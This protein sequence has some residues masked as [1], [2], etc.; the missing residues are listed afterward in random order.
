MKTKT[1][2]ATVKLDVR[3]QA[4]RQVVFDL[5]E[6]Q[7]LPPIEAVIDSMIYREG[8]D[9]FNRRASASSTLNS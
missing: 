6:K 3:E 2:K 8:L 1:V 4:Q 5:V 7:G 9:S